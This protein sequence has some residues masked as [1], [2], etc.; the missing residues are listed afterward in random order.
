MEQAGAATVVEDEDLDAERLLAEVQPLLADPERLREMAAA[1]R[2]LA[3]PD[4]A[5]RVA[6]EILAAVAAGRGR[7]S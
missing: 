1:S 6:A 3:R 4:A 5:D 7:A 2:L